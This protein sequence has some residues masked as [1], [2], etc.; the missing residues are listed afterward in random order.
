MGLS[1]DLQAEWPEVPAG[2]VLQRIPAPCLG[3]LAGVSLT[4]LA[5]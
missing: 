4:G 5:S 3:A 2:V 1:A